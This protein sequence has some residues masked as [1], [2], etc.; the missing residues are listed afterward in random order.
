[1]GRTAG[2]EPRGMAATNAC[3]DT[4]VGGPSAFP[5]FQFSPGTR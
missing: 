1:M 3:Y 4:N 5:F 2:E